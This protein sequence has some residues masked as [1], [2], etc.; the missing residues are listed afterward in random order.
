MKALAT[1]FAFGLFLGPVVAPAAL[2]QGAPAAITEQEAH[3]IGVDAYV[4]F[5]SLISID[6]TRRQATNAEPGKMVLFGPANLFASAPAFPTADFRAV[7]RPNFDT[8]YSS[9]WLDMTKEPVVVSAP[10][11]GGRYYLLPMLD[12]WSDVF[13]SPGWR[14]TGTQAAN[15]LVTPPGWSGTVPDGMTTSAR[16]LPCMGLFLSRSFGRAAH[17]FPLSVSLFDLKAR[18]FVPTRTSLTLARAGAVKVGRRANL[19]ACS[20]LARPHRDSSEHDG[21]LGAVG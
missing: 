9:A 17:F 13:A 15:Y 21:P 18:F 4:Y 1:A 20:T 8:L 7:V 16:R 5:Y 19:A 10:D 6:V 12:M 11:T 14:T 3:A 2:A